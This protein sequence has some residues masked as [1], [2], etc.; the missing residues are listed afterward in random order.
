MTNTTNNIPGRVS[1]DPERE[2]FLVERQLSGRYA[3]E[4][5]R[6]ERDQIIYFDTREN[7]EAFA[8]KKRLAAPNRNYWATHTRTEE[9]VKPG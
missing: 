7:A 1:F 9:E 6:D 4:I 3:T 2:Q 5:V 8:Y